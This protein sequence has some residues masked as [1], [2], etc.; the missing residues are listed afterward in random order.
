M[1]IRLGVISEEHNIN[2][3]SHEE[4]NDC[5]LLYVVGPQRNTYT[6][7]YRYPPTGA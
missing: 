3:L 1:K 5:K 4:Y 7:Y 2:I 6:E